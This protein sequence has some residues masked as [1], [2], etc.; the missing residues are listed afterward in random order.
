MSARVGLYAIRHQRGGIITAPLFSAPPS[1]ERIAAEKARLDRIHGPGWVRPVHVALELAPE[2]AD[3]AERFA[4]PPEPEPPPEPGTAGALP[5]IV[6]RAVG[7]YT[8]P[9]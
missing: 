4:P 9:R 6:I 7:T 5:G 2:H 8:P 3:L 1:E